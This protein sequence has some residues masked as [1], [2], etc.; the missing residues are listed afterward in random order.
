MFELKPERF[1]KLT[2][3]KKENKPIIHSFTLFSA[4]LSNFKKIFG[5]EFE[6]YKKYFEELT[7]TSAF[8]KIKVN[9]KEIFF[10]PYPKGRKMFDLSENEK[11][12][13]TLMKNLKKL[14]FIE[15][16]ILKEWS[17]KYNKEKESMPLDRD[18]IKGIFYSDEDVRNF[19]TRTTELKTMVYRVPIKEQNKTKTNELFERDVFI[20]NENFSFYFLIKVPKE[21]K[22]EIK[23]TILSIEGIGGKRSSGYGQFEINIINNKVITNFLN[24]EVKGNEGMLIN[25]ILLNHEINPISYT[26]VEFGGYFDISNKNPLQPKPQLFYLEEGSFIENKNLDNIKNKEERFK[27]NKLFIYKKP[28]VI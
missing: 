28:W 5:D 24:K 3:N 18:K 16:E 25:S 23:K 14:T 11:N 12:D 8:P 9:N 15:F 1:V 6:N 10:L 19:F 13:R 26:L 21:I 17:E 22:E 2:Q 20:F 27:E 7:L 4:I